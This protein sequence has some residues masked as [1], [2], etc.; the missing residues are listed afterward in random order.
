MDLLDKLVELLGD[1]EISLEEYRRILDA[2]YEEA[3]IGIL[4]PGYDRIVFGDM[5]RTRLDRIRALF[6][7]GVNDGVIPGTGQ[8]DGILSEA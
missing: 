7:V 5:E 8:A 4:P 2:G 3:K 1:E 6:V